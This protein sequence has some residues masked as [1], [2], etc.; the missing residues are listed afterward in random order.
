MLPVSTDKH[1][2][3]IAA[4]LEEHNQP[5]RGKLYVLIKKGQLIITAWEDAGHKKQTVCSFR[6]KDAHLGFTPKQWDEIVA[7]LRQ[8]MLNGTL[9]EIKE[10][11]P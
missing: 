1:L 4:W 10:T 11:T 8:A 6:R 7:R 9:K 3:Q 5:C 2:N